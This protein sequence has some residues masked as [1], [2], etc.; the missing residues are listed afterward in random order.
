MVAFMCDARI[1]PPAGAESGSGT[2]VP[3]FESANNAELETQNRNY[4]DASDTNF[5]K[6]RGF[7]LRGRRKNPGRYER[8]DRNRSAELLLGANPLV[9]N[10]PSWS[11]A[12]RFVGRRLPRVRAWTSGGFNRVKPSQT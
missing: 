4:G 7:N 11:S 9:I 3:S 5:A 1:H 8:L 6:G 10:E 12:L 2:R